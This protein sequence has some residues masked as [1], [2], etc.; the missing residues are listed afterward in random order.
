[1]AVATWDGPSGDRVRLFSVKGTLT[2][3]DDGCVRLGTGSATG[4]VTPIW[5]DGSEVERDGASVTVDPDG[6]A[7]AIEV[8]ER[9]RLGG[10]YPS[11]QYEDVTC[12][13]QD[14][15]PAFEVDQVITAP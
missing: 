1:M 4:V 8:G 3:D 6:D 12:G 5:P 10:G 15:A 9:V 13:G 2:L 11:E 14:R 7:D